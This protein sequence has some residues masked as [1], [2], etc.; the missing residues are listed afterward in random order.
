VS[1]ARLFAL[2]ACCEAADQG[3]ADLNADIYEALGYRVVRAPQKPGGIYWRFRGL[4]KL[5]NEYHSHWEVQ[6]D[7]TRSL[8]AAVTLAPKGCIWS[9]HQSGSAS[10]MDGVGGDNWTRAKTTPLAL[11]AAILRARATQEQSA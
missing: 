7:F 5:S 10:C 3:S 2:A 6:Q 8:D 1:S 9:V 4:G 11:C